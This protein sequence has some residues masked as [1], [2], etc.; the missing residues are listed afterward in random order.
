MD[1]LLFGGN[2][3]EKDN[4]SG[5]GKPG[6]FMPTA[7]AGLVGLPGMAMGMGG[8]TMQMTNAHSVDESQG[9]LSTSNGPIEPKLPT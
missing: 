9:S 5:A 3:P 1:A 4:K 8:F 6:F 2:T 7:G